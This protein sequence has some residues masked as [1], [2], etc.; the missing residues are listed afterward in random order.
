MDNELL[1][2][3]L[4]SPLCISQPPYTLLAI[5]FHF[6]SLIPPLHPT[7]P[8]EAPWS[9]ISRRYAAGGSHRGRWQR[10]WV[11]LPDDEGPGEDVVEGEK[12]LC[13]FPRFRDQHFS[14]L[15]QRAVSP[16]QQWY[17]PWGEWAAMFH[18]RFPWCK[19]SGWGKYWRYL[20]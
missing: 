13:M 14:N 18:R 20:D 7:P 19:C 15:V 17:L 3:T 6:P 5:P 8:L 4:W 11:K 16:A 9:E 1:T 12:H 10:K 2:L